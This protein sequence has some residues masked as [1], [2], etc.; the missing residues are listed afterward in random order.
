MV[1]TKRVCVIFL[2]GGLCVVGAARCQMP[3]NPPKF[4]WNWRDSQELNANQSLRNAKLSQ[5]EKRA[6]AKALADQFRPVMT[7]LEIN[8][9]EQLQKAALDTRIKLIDLNDDGIPEV[10]AQGMAGC[11]PTGN[12]SFWIFQR[13]PKG[14]RLLLEGE[15]QSF[16]IQPTSTE[17]FRDIV[18]SMHGSATDS[19][20]TEYWYMDG[21]YRDVGCYDA[22]WIVFEGDERRELKE[23]RIT[24]CK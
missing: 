3:T 15:A 22:S 18:L 9:E 14:Y 12:C 24:P 7:D 13:S 4:H 20:L 21:T 10:V 17:G 19:G 1:Q 8:S 5:H 16:T 23:P 2:I 6:I 11:S